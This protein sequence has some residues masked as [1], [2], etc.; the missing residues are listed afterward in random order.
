MVERVLQQQF[1]NASTLF[2]PGDVPGRVDSHAPE[3]VTGRDVQRFAVF[4]SETAVR[5]HVGRESN[6]IDQLAF[7][8]N[9]VDARLVELGVCAAASE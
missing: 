8:G 2:W 9:H 3:F 7:E 6:E 5:D 1:P 4:V